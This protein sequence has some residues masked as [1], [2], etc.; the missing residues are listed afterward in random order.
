MKIAFCSDL[1]LESF[2]RNF[3]LP[4]ADLLLL[5]GDILV[6]S[7]LRREFSGIQA[8]DNQRQFLIDVASKYETVL[9]V[10]GNHEYYDSCIDT[11][12][13]NVNDFLKAECIDNITFGAKGSLTIHGVKFVCATLWTDI[14]KANPVAVMNGKYVMNDYVFITKADASLDS[15][16]RYLSTQDTM[17]IHHE[18]RNHIKDEIVGHDKVVVMTHHAPHMLSSGSHFKDTSSAYYCCTDIEDIILDNPQIK[19]WVAGHTHNRIEY[20]I[21]DT[22][23]HSNPRGYGSEKISSDFVIKTFEL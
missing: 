2:G 22:K 5:A 4:D 12:E 9:W 17:N 10:P 20:E 21:G 19:F 6:V 3:E 8:C 14:N 23:I 1:H 7:D 18:H 15:G 13:K 11:V 16:I